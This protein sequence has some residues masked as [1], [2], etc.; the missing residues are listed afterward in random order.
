MPLRNIIALLRA[1]LIWT[2]FVILLVLIA[3]QAGRANGVFSDIDQ[4]PLIISLGFWE[5]P[6]AQAGTSLEADKTAVGFWER[7]DGTDRTGVRGQVCVSNTG[8]YPTE[9]LSIADIVQINAGSGG[10]SDYIAT[11][12]DVSRHP[13]LL[14][15]ESHCYPYEIEFFPVEGAKYRNLAHASITNHAGWLPGSRNCPGPDSC[16]FGPEVKANFKLPASPTIITEDPS[17]G[18]DPADCNRGQ[19]ILETSTADTSRAR[20]GSLITKSWK[21]KNSGTCIWTSEYHAVFRGDSRM[22]A[23]AALPI[24]EA[25][26]LPQSELELSVTLKAPEKPGIYPGGYRLLAADDQPVYLENGQ[27][28]FLWIN[29][30]VLETPAGPEQTAGPGPIPSP[31]LANSPTPTTSQPTSIPSTSTQR[32]TPTL[33][34]TL[35]APSDNCVKT[36]D[37]WLAHPESW[38]ATEVILGGQS[39]SKEAALAILESHVEDDAAFLVAQQYIVTQLNLLDGA[40]G[41]SIEATLQ[42]AEMWLRDYPP[43]SSPSGAERERG[44]RIASRLADYNNG[45]IGP[46]LCDSQALPTSAPPEG[47]EQPSST[48]SPMPTQTGLEAPTPTSAPTLTPSSTLLPPTLPSP[49]PT[50]TATGSAE[51][52][53]TAI[54]TPTPAAEDGGG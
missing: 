47:T 38:P 10:F 25:P 50:V 4:V 6:P 19:I 24:G 16:P 17:A 37:F 30:T 7:F 39:Y 26:V 33:A 3:M 11:G 45:W 27:D 29:L 44:L 20:P 21:I 31:T 22:N 46:V 51:T 2:S 9:N 23:P 18:F 28:N 32:P 52:S 54:T 5:T 14:P 40:S 12:I 35:P 13:S 1:W 49:T 53:P 43:G 15:G 41:S 36:Q 48:T 8:D 34:P 42:E